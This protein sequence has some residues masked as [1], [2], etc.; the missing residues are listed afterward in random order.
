MPGGSPE[1]NV[2]EDDTSDNEDLRP[3]G[4]FKLYSYLVRAIEV[5]I[6]ISIRNQASQGGVYPRARTWDVRLGVF[7]CTSRDIKAVWTLVRITCVKRT[8]ML[9]PWRHWKVVLSPAASPLKT[10]CIVGVGFAVT[11]L[12]RRS[13]SGAVI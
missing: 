5:S 13:P 8:P 9:P 4:E 11:Y 6:L 3:Q 10:P 1:F 7:H 2:E 12:W